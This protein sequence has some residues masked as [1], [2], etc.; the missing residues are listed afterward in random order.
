MGGLKGRPL[1]FLKS[2]PLRTAPARSTQ[3]GSPGTDGPWFL[4][5]IISRG[6][7][8]WRGRVPSSKHRFGEDSPGGGFLD[9]PRTP[10]GGFLSFQTV[11]RWQHVGPLLQ[12]GGTYHVLAT[13]QPYPEQCGGNSRFG[14]RQAFLGGV[15][16]F[17][18]ITLKRP[19]F[20]FPIPSHL[21]K[22]KTEFP[23]RIASVEMGH[24]EDNAKEIRWGSAC[25]E[26]GEQ[27]LSIPAQIRNR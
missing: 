16:Q 4:M 23:H 14:L 2:R 25:R 9:V 7:H 27:G 1:I 12:E 22:M 3:V 10:A 15:S 21:V 19:L 17:F 5:F 26:C 11:G 18:F 6:Q 20:H 8:E 13:Y 24:K